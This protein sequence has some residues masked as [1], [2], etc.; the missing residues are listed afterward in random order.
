MLCGGKAAAVSAHGKWSFRSVSRRKFVRVSGFLS[1][2]E[3][4]HVVLEFF[5]FS[6]FSMSTTATVWRS[7]RWEKTGFVVS[8]RFSLFRVRRR[9]RESSE[10]LFLYIAQSIFRQAHRERK[11]WYCSSRDSM[12]GV[13][14]SYSNIMSNENIVTLVDSCR[15]SFA[16]CW[17]K[18]ERESFV[19][20]W[21]LNIFHIN[22]ASA[23]SFLLS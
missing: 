18:S 21:C 10:F 19:F 23:H 17:F 2:G 4:R 15:R 1:L 14:R 8:V 6:F 9:K 7:N 12:L 3:L 11:S 5:S 13:E 22:M 20:K 16:T